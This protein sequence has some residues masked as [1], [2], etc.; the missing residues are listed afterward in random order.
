MFGHVTL[1]DA[2]PSGIGVRAQETLLTLRLPRE[3]F[4]RVAMQYP[5][6]LMRV[7]ELD[8]IAIVAQ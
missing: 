4:A 5:A 7:S 6:M 2:S 3:A 1:I 8:P